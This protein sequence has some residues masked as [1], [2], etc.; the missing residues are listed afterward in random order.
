MYAIRHVAMLSPHATGGASPPYGEGEYLFLYPRVGVRSRRGNYR[1]GS[2]SGHRPIP[3]HVHRLVRFHP[4]FPT[5]M[6]PHFRNN[7]R[8]VNTTR[9]K[10]RR[11]R[12]G[13][14]RPFNFLPRVPT[15]GVDA[16]KELNFR[17]PVHFFRRHQGRTRHGNR[18][19]YR[20]VN[21]RT[22]ATRQ[23][24]G[25][26]S[27]IYRSS[28]THDVHR[29]QEGTSGRCGARYRGRAIPR[30][31]FAS[32]S[33]PMARCFFPQYN[34]RVSR[35]HGCRGSPRQL[36]HFPSRSEQRTQGRS[37]SRHRCHRGRMEP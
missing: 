21:E 36:R 32:V 22:G 13:K 9:H 27:P 20:F 16:T 10:G 30:A 33:G 25:H 3:E 37:T 2:Y 17:S 28:E 31:F 4:P 34:R 24:W 19:R 1:G 35:R 8:V 23:V 29:R 26:F 5:T 12:G 7:H 6:T 18:R 11:E 15:N 14:R